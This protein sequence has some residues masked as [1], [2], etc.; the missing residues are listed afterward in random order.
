MDLT[1]PYVPEPGDSTKY[2]PSPVIDTTTPVNKRV[3]THIRVTDHGVGHPLFVGT[4][5]PTRGLLKLAT[6]SANS[7]SGLNLVEGDG[8]FASMEVVDPGAV[9]EP[10][11]SIRSVADVLDSAS[12]DP[13]LATK[14]PGAVGE[15][16]V[17][18][19]EIVMGVPSTSQPG[20]SAEE[21]PSKPSINH[22][23][24]PPVM[25]ECI[26]DKD[27]WCE[28]HQAK[29]KEYWRPGK[30]MVKG[31]RGKATVMKHE[32]ENYFS[33]DIVVKGKGRMKQMTLSSYLKTTDNL[34][35][36]TQ[37]NSVPIP[38][39][40]AEV[41]RGDLKGVPNFLKTVKED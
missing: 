19:P 34:K 8:Q 15:E 16:E 39:I 17:P 5:S 24:N 9:E 36:R 41:L 33:C 25:R 38:D 37:N 32:K 6:T 27:G 1:L 30:G 22:D 21:Q 12:G 2:P 28:V 11:V 4:E 26:H 18:D 29:A 20:T 10:G 35:T 7:L 14:S 13:E 3:G 23:I 31:K 40:D